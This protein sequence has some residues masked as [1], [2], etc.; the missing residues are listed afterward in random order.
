L[1]WPHWLSSASEMPTKSSAVGK[2][3]PAVASRGRPR[4]PTR[5][6]SA[7]KISAMRGLRMN[8]EA[9]GTSMARSVSSR[10]LQQGE[11]GL[12]LETKIGNSQPVEAAKP[13]VVA[14]RQWIEVQE[15]LIL[16]SLSWSWTLGGY[17]T[18]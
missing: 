8:L 9:W 18:S 1:H 5:P 16:F 11:T 12:L 2:T 6:G 15:Q 7:T 14:G 17:C 10:K 4:Q 13:M 3:V